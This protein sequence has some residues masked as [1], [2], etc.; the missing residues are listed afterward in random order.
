MALPHTSAAKTELVLIL[1]FQSRVAKTATGNQLKYV[2]FV[3]G[4]F[5]T[6]FKI[7]KKGM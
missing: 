5:S 1:T 7:N 4:G 6:V 3:H 2:P